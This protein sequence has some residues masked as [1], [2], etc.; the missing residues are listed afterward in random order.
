[1]NSKNPKITLSLPPFFKIY[2]FLFYKFSNYSDWK[3]R[4]LLVLI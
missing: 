1:M 2:L 3:I 4:K